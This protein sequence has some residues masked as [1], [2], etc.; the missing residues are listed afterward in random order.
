MEIANVPIIPVLG[1]DNLYARLKQSGL[2]FVIEDITPQNNNPTPH[3]I[4]TM[5]VSQNASLV[6]VTVN[7][8]FYKE[9]SSA[10]NFKKELKNSGVEALFII[11]TRIALN[12][13]NNNFNGAQD[14]GS[15][16]DATEC[17]LEGTVQQIISALSGESPDPDGDIDI[18][19][20]SA[21]APRQPEAQDA[22]HEQAAPQEETA[23]PPIPEAEGVEY[24]QDGQGEAN[25]EVEEDYQ[26][27]TLLEKLDY[28][29][30]D[31][32]GRISKK[33][34][35]VFILL[36]LI[37]ILLLV[38]AFKQPVEEL[39]ETEPP[40]AEQQQEPSD[41]PEYSE[42][43]PAEAETE[44]APDASYEVLSD[45][46]KEAQEGYDAIMAVLQGADTSSIETTTGEGC[47]AGV[48]GGAV[49]Y[50]AESN[51]IAIAAFYLE[52]TG[53]EAYS[54]YDKLYIGAEQNGATLVVDDKYLQGEAAG[55]IYKQIQPGESSVIYQAYRLDGSDANVV[56]TVEP[57]DANSTPI[58]RQ[59]MT[60][61]N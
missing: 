17:D 40:T 34:W 25:E 36:A 28:F 6:M 61:A 49:T 50:D 56:I 57:W 30:R 26:P 22:Y 35:L 27:E 13:Y 43:L 16:I 10:K 45:P 44:D 14:P 48:V 41:A 9:S 29:F 47:K 33:G 60:T 3:E 21:E 4:V 37:V 8:D 51:P 20:K 31:D 11:K 19:S 38:K 23:A 12:S 39:P 55:G 54:L 46:A 1:D 59:Y 52:N 24:E 53:S 5:A 42:E 2:S 32:D 15:I 7:D 18:G 58:S